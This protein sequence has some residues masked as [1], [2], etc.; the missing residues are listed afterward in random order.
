MHFLKSI[1]NFFAKSVPFFLF[2]NYSFFFFFKSVFWDELA[3]LI[4]DLDIGIQ[5]ACCTKFIS[6]AF[7]L[8][9]YF[10][11]LGSYIYPLIC[12]H[13]PWIVQ[14]TLLT[15]LI[16]KYMEMFLM[17]ITYSIIK[18]ATHSLKHFEAKEVICLNPKG[19][20]LY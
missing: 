7:I 20:D 8:K 10:S 11:N 4:I 9:C 16:S 5:K 18:I 1:D 14:C 17:G 2:A 12:L 6:V 15:Q 19:L 3:F 13:F